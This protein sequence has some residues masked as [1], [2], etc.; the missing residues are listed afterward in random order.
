MH[1][2]PSI[3]SD[4]I[5]GLNLLIHHWRQSQ[6]VLLFTSHLLRKIKKTEGPHSHAGLLSCSISRCK[7]NSYQR[8]SEKG[9]I[10][11][12]FSFMPLACALFRALAES[13]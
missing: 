10:P 5:V 12:T 13:A 9:Y 8:L 2:R 6:C 7:I 1:G 11:K 3:I 4:Q